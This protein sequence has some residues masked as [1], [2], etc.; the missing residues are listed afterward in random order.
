MTRTIT[1]RSCYI[2]IALWIIISLLALAGAF[3]H[4]DLINSY[5]EESGCRES[6]LGDGF[7]CPDLKDINEKG[8]YR[9]IMESGNHVPISDS[10]SGYMNTVE[11][12]NT[13][14]SYM[15]L[16]YVIIFIGIQIVALICWN[17]HYKWFG[18]ELKSCWSDK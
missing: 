3:H 4:V 7:I 6:M 13:F 18:I 9:A 16:V 2:T 12:F 8:H 17:D 15:I 11:N 5:D 1:I 10:N 14:M